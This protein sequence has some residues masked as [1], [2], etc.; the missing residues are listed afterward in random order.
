MW[1]PTVVDRNKIM[2]EKV[3]WRLQIHKCLGS[4]MIPRMKERGMNA[5]ETI[6]MTI[7]IFLAITRTTMTGRRS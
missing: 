7:A 1:T 6:A 5:V 2:K 4:R 3:D